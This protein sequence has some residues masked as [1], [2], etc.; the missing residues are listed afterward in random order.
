MHADII[1]EHYYQQ[2]GWFLQNAKRYDN[3]DKNGSKVF[4][5]EYAAQSDHTVSVNNKN[6]WL[7]ALSEAAFMTGLERN[8]DVVYMASYAPL[9]A[10]IDAWQWTPDLIW[11]NNLQSYGTTDYQVQ[12]I[13]SLNKGT[14]EISILQ[15]AK[16]I[17][18]DDSLYAAA[19]IDKN[20]NEVIIKLVNASNKKQDKQININ[21]EK[22]KSEGKMI[23]LQSDDLT[24]M[25]SFENPFNV[26]PKEEN[27]SI[28]N[29]N[30]NISLLPYSFTI[31]KLNY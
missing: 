4:A 3:Y 24:A 13:Y 25:N 11:V 19:A 5:G 6:N 14:N 8:A 17:A 22:I 21:G 30:I 10:N 1:D 31:I 2:P 20:T 26:S 28:K 16:E 15:N 29:K 23:V 27:I 12:K 7:T 18:G 9:F